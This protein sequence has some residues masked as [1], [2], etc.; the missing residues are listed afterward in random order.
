MDFREISIKASKRQ[1][2][3]QKGIIQKKYD[4]QIHQLQM[5][6]DREIERLEKMILRQ[7]EAKSFVNQPDSKKTD[8]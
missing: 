5:Q 6:R 4:S 1:L 3:E 8:T 2:A 7:I